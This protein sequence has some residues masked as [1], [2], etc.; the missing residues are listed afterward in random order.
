MLESSLKQL[1]ADSPY[2]RNISEDG[3]RRLIEAPIRH[4]KAIIVRDS[5][6]VVGFSTYAF[7]FKHQVEGYLNRTRKIKSIDFM[8]ENGE[9]WFIDFIAPYKNAKEVLKEV[10]AEFGKRYPHIYSAKMFRRAKGYEA[11]VFRRQQ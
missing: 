1:L 5:G 2:H 4:G 9:L 3:I 7:L 6:R 8:R 11:R 10:K